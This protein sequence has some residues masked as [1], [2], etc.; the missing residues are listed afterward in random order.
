MNMPA[1][2]LFCYSVHNALIFICNLYVNLRSCT[3]QLSICIF[4]CH[5]CLEAVSASTKNCK[6]VLITN[7]GSHLLAAV[8]RIGPSD[9]LVAH[10]GIPLQKCSLECLGSKQVI[11]SVTESSSK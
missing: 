6:K 5:E 9:H 7:S 1:Q 4:Y 11:W 8:A 10:L 2:T 3:C